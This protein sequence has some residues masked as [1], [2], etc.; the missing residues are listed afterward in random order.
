MIS[1]FWAVGKFYQQIRVN[2]ATLLQNGQRW[3]T[4][5]KKNQEH[6]SV[7][8]KGLDPQKEYSKSITRA[9]SNDH[10]VITKLARSTNPGK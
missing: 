7:L 6:I 10:V 9:I 1:I 4:F 8:I 2:G 5:K 3:E